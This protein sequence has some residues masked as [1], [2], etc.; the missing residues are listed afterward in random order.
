MAGAAERRYWDP[1]SARVA[2]LIR[3]A[4]QAVIDNPAELIAAIDDASFEANRDLLALE[5]RLA[6]GIRAATRSN[7]T[8]WVQANL[9]EP[10]LPVSANAG[11]ENMN[12]ARDVVRHGF[13]ET[14]LVGFRASQ[15]VVIERWNDL[16][17]EL[18][19]ET[20]V[21]RELLAVVY[22]SIFAY[23]D[24]TVEAIFEMI[25][26]E[27]TQ[28]TDATH[29][30]RLE[31]VSLILEGAPISTRRAS[32]RLRYDLARTH[33]AGVVWSDAD[34]APGRREAAAH[35][36]AR[37][38]GAQRPLSLPASA[39]TLWLWISGKGAPDLD[40]MRSVLDG[41]ANVRATLGRPGI[42]MEGFRDSHLEAVAAQRLVRRLPV[43]SAVTAYEDVEVVALAM[44]DEERAREFV[45]RTLGPLVTAPVELRDTLRVYLREE[46][47]VAR[48][49]NVLFTH[50]NTVMGRL[51]RA[52]T[53]LPDGLDGRVLQVGLALEILHVLGSP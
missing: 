28:L 31:V 45:A 47:T 20:D 24:D 26:R 8:H 51:D 5:P 50:R 3:T 19:A 13:D 49:A 34:V 2:E 16:A 36:L 7:L 4:S 48:T 14:I 21:L 22:R 6:D 23:V 30:A 35:A 15:N 18:T 40:A 52:R 12:F 25:R 11:P 9:H 42:G 33:V 44:Q 53:L 1:P 39:S 17:F 37:A 41:F 32:D 27:R 43:R 38:A 29:I 46:C 10:G